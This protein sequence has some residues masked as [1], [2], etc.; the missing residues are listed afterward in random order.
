MKEGGNGNNEENTR[1]RIDEGKK[2]EGKAG[3]VEGEA[4]ERD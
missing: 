4:V 3:G 2:E 1:H